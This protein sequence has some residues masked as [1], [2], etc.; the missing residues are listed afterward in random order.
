VGV[1]GCGTVGGALV[2]ILLEDSSGIADRSGIALE[3]VGVAV[4]DASRDRPGIPRELITDDAAALVARPD[5]DVIVE[6]IG[7]LE[8]AGSLIKEALE[9]GKAVVTAN[10]ALLA[11]RGA[12]LA[13]SAAASGVDLLYEAAV[14]GAIPIIRPLRESLAGERVRR[15]MGIVNGTT[16]FILSTMTEN[17]VSYEDALDD[18]QRLGYAEKDPAADVEGHDA[19][20]KAAIL[21]GLAFRRDVV[22]TDVPRQGISGIPSVDVAY[23]G[24]L[25]YAVKLLA[26]AELV[27]D[28]DLSVRVHPA[29]VP[30]THPLAS[31]RGVFNAV[32]IEGESCGDLM[33]YGRG[34]G[35]APTA[36]AVLGDIIDAAHNRVGGGAAPEPPRARATLAPLGDVINP[37]YLSIE[38]QDRPGVLAEVTAVFGRRGVSIRSMEQQGL[39]DEAR[40]VFL[41]HQARHGDVQQTLTD[42]QA[43]EVV[44]HV[45]AVLPV[46]GEEPER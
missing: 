30:V 20:A 1:L 33:L 25:G 26:I 23:A 18:A 38:V 9:S 21:A 32:F 42:L 31:V 29:L 6:L 11:A 44:G 16:N 41:T 7:G 45:G 3:V 19:A 5:V 2:R 8:P 36:S 34:A 10:K 40:L 39:G 12:E 4:S 46:V 14:A 27:G 37:F 24:R 43:L 35:G 17:Q 13:K 15:V 28:S 22:D